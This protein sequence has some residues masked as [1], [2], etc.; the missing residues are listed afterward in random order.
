M[1]QPFEVAGHYG[2]DSLLTRVSESLARAGLGGGQESH[3]IDWSALAPL[4]QFHARGLAASRELAEELNLAADAHV[5][6]IGSGLGGPARFLA[7]TYGVRVSGVDLSAPFVEIATLLSER[8]GLADRVA[9]RQADALALPFDASSFDHAWTQH[10]AMNISNR[11]RLYS[12]IHRVLRPGGLFAIYDVL[13]ADGGPI[14]FPV[15][16]ARESATSF[17]VDLDGMRKVLT[18]SGFVELS[19]ADKTVVVRDWFARQQRAKTEVPPLGLQVVMGE[20]FTGMSAN[21]ARNLAENRARLVQMI[22]QK[23]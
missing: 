1:T 7:A 2:K 20:E 17:L 3:A 22:V 13:A 12:E 8:T 15:P 16:W 5:L 6:D 19:C 23:T 10:V 11:P 4:D 9:F 21:F 14:V 18:E